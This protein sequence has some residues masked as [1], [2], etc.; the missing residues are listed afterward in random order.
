MTAAVAHELQKA[1]RREDWP[2]A[3]ELLRRL[4]AQNDGHASLHYNLGLVLRRQNQE[5]SA[6]AAFDAALARDANHPAAGF[7]RAAVLLDMGEHGAAEAG[8]RKQ[9]ARDPSD[10]DVRLNL[11]R[12]A[13]HRD[14][15]AEALDLVADDARPAARLVAVEALRDL[16]WLDEMQA[17]ASC[18]SDQAPGLKPML[19][20]IMSQGPRGRLPLQAGLV[21]AAPGTSAPPS[22]KSRR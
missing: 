4:I 22:R 14:A 13:L 11:A 17:L 2:L 1:L 16:A 6:L 21:F 19:L 15:P 9:L 7:E 5:A 8:F 10:A 20:K 3:E 12:L 18:L